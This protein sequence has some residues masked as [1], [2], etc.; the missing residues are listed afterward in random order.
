MSDKPSYLG[1]LNAIAVA[2]RRAGEYLACWIAVTPNPD[3]AKVLHTIAL[4]EAEHGLAF[5]KRLDELGYGVIVKPSKEHSKQMKV[6]A[7]TELSDRQ[8][9]EKLKLG[10]R[11]AAGD[12]DVF[13][14]FFEN[15]DID[16]QTGGLLGRYIAEERDT[17]RRLAGCY[18]ALCA[19][20]G[21]APAHEEASGDGH[22]P[23]AEGADASLQELADLVA[24][25][26]RQLADVM[27][28]LGSSLSTRS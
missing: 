2:E 3:V 1:L 20:G 11:L 25:A 14:R 9:F 12:S 4:R 27:R 5:E 10:R 6:A 22:H 28:R 13:D 16:P 18:E 7:S 19:D 24:S 26:G 17:G 21:L 15:K 23:R 8:K